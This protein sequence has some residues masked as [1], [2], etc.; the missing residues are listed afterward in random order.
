[1]EEGAHGRDNFRQ[2]ILSPFLPSRMVSSQ[3][4]GLGFLQAHQLHGQGEGWQGQA[5]RD[6]RV[7][8]TKKK[9][10]QSWK[11]AC[12]LGIARFPIHSTSI[13]DPLTGGFWGLWGL[14]AEAAHR[15][16][17]T[18]WPASQQARRAS[19]SNLYFLYFSLPP[20]L[21]SLLPSQENIY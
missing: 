7:F 15:K 6:G 16:L 3:A 5:L 14:G 12:A 10:A 8:Y 4:P 1:M 11:E 17:T 2:A 21:P 18:S 19:G 13:P 20:F 9:R